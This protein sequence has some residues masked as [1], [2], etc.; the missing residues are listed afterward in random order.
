MSP[1]GHYQAGKQILTQVFYPLH[2]T[3][4]TFS[5]LSIIILLQI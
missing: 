4:V 5:F 1:V 3:W 2:P